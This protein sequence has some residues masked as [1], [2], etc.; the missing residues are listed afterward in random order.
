MDN[1]IEMAKYC[2]CHND[3]G[4]CE[5]R[6]YDNCYKHLVLDLLLTIDDLKTERLHLSADFEATKAMLDG[7]IEG[8]ET[9]QRVLSDLRSKTAEG[10][11]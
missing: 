10:N 8:Q 5:Y 2:V 1:I 6:R 7:A 4:G 9:L 3:C 11:M